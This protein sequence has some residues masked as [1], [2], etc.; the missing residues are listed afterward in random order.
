[1]MPRPA[2]TTPSGAT[3]ILPFLNTNPYAK[4][5]GPSTRTRDGATVLASGSTVPA[6]HVPVGGGGSSARAGTAAVMSRREASTHAWWRAPVERSTFGTCP[7]AAF[8]ERMP[9][10][11]C[12]TSDEQRA[13]LT[14]GVRVRLASHAAEAMERAA[15]CTRACTALRARRLR[16]N[17]ADRGAV[18]YFARM[19]PACGYA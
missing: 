13:C 14:T 3:T 10:A 5:P 16:K 7:A 4:P 6:G 19:R 18:T 12:L 11:R 8:A 15:I 9:A 17:V 1:M 2:S